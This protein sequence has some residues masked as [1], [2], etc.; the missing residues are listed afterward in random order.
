[1]GQVGR[2]LCHQARVNGETFALFKLK[3]AWVPDL[4]PSVHMPSCQHVLD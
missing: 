4:E 2:V 1:V 3:H